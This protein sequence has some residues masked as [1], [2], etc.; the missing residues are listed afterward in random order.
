MPP[1]CK[2]SK[3]KI[4]KAA[5]DM[6]REKGIDSVTARALGARLGSSSRPIFSLFQ[7]MQE[8]QEEVMKS[9]D[10]MYQ[11]YLKHGMS[12]GEYPVYKASGMAYIRFAKEEK[13]LFKLLLMSD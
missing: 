3:E 5:L 9:A 4:V 13:E 8:V 11:D 2:F 7:S 1:K 10:T 12:S 6:T